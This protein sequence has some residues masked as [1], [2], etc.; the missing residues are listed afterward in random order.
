[1]HIGRTLIFAV[2]VTVLYGCATTQ[3]E[4]ELSPAGQRGE[5][6]LLSGIRNYED[7]KYNEAVKALQSSLNRGLSDQ[8]QVRAH[9][10]LAFIHCVSE[11]D[12]KCRSHFRMALTINPR[13]ELEPAETGHPI[14]GPVF[15]SVKNQR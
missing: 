10:Y 7:G 6:S 1:M 3:D 14:W 15:R 12:A 9:K 8:E 11:Q 2:T 5:P 4:S 13:F